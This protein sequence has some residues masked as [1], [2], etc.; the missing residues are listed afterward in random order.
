MK[1]SLCRRPIQA[2]IIRAVEARK[3]SIVVLAMVSTMALTTDLLAYLKRDTA[4]ANFGPTDW[5]AVSK[6]CMFNG[7]AQA[8]HLKGLSVDDIEWPIDSGNRWRAAQSIA[9]ACHC[10]NESGTAGP[11]VRLR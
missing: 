1:L 9:S 11:A 2:C 5:E 10:R 4:T 3:C 8:E 7:L 6:A